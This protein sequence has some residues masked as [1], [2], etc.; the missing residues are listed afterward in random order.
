MNKSKKLTAAVAATA[1]ASAIVAPVASASVSFSDIEG[2]YAKDAIL[3]LANAGIIV[4]ENGKF[5]PSAKINRQDFAI[6]MAKALGLDLNNKPA[7]ATFSDIPTTH[8]SFVAV[9]AAVKAGLL[10]GIGGGKFGA[11]TSLTREQMAVVFVNAL[12]VDVAGKGADLKFADASSISSW[13]KDA[14]AYAVEAKLLSGGEGNKFNPQASA[15]RQQVAVVASNFLKVKEELSVGTITAV[16][17]LDNTNLKVTFSKA[18]E[19]ADKADFAVKAKATGAA[20][21]VASVTLSDDKKSAT[22][23]LTAPLAAATAYTVSYKHKS[24]EITTPQAATVEVA[25]TGAKKLTVTFNQA[26]DTAKADFAV[27]KGTVAVNVSSVT[28]SEDKKSAVLVL[29]TKLTKGDYTVSVTGVQESAV[30]DTVSVE[31][32]TVASITLGS[33]KAAAKL[34][35]AGIIVGATVTYKVVNQYGEDLTNNTPNI[36]WTTGLG[37]AADDNAGLVELT[38]NFTKGQ[39]VVLTGVDSTSNKVVTGTLTVSD[40]ATTSELTFGELYNAEDE[41]LTTTSDFSDFVIT[42]GGKDQYGNTATKA[43]LENDFIVTSS[44]PLVATVEN[45]GGSNPAPT[46]STE[47]GKNEDSLGLTLVRPANNIAGTAT[48]R[49]INKYT[50]KD[51]TFNV[52]VVKAAAVDTVTLSAPTETIAAGDTVS[53]PFSVLDQNGN[54]FKTHS[55]LV[56]GLGLNATNG[57]ISLAYDYVAKKSVLNFTANAKGKATITL[58][59]TS[60]KAPAT[61]IFDVVDARTPA[62][63]SKVVDLKGAVAVGAT[64]KLTAANLQVVDQYGKA[65]TIDEDFFDDYEIAVDVAGTK[66]DADADLITSVDDVIT[67][68]GVAKGTEKIKLTLRNAADSSEVAGSSIEFNV[69]AVALSDIASYEIGDVA[70]IYDDNA[71]GYQVG[72][73]VYGKLTDGTKVVLPNT[74]FTATSTKAGLTYSTATRKLDANGVTFGDASEVTGKVKVVIVTTG[75]NLEKEVTI[76]NVAP[77]ATTFK[78]V[79]TNAVAITSGVAAVAA[80]DVNT[81]NLLATFTAK[82]Q[83]GVAFDLDDATVTYS[84]LKGAGLNVTNNGQDNASI[85][86]AAAGNT[87]VMTIILPSGKSAFI[88]VVVK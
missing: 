87:F 27:K 26:V 1:V 15:E 73:D 40:A 44:N 21:E 6:I 62:V 30:S 47:V 17:Y 58:A 76:T 65:V 61:I 25:A 80:A 38:Y 84:N 33:D 51:F 22:V 60:G 13:A 82:D 81:A 10:S 66:V 83:Y 69:K 68:T 20:A 4:G 45:T 88:N 48:I 71:A 14:V 54:E 24:L 43:Q 52:T 12:G 5:N 31:N 79:S 77:T 72:F 50:G 42:L 74:A 19:A 28:F 7:T 3:E 78:N 86:G 16:E 11:N 55:G 18:L 63:V 64:S 37:T 8:Y 32:E 9:E 49:L 41:E 36:N 53:I 67:L 34:D 70:K 75:E 23:K 35:G 29:T 2:S 46:V 57:N 85:T 39:T 59:P 56:A